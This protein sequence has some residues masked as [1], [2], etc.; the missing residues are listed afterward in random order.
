[1]IAPVPRRQWDGP[2]CRDRVHPLQDSVRTF[3]V[4]ACK[5]DGGKQ[6]CDRQGILAI[7]ERRSSEGRACLMHDG[8]IALAPAPNRLDQ[9]APDTGCDARLLAI[10]HSPEIRFDQHRR[11]YC[12]Y[13]GLTALVLDLRQGGVFTQSSSKAP[14]DALAQILRGIFPAARADPVMLRYPYDHLQAAQALDL[15]RTSSGRETGK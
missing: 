6:A 15:A 5:A 1:M 12:P 8:V 11:A 2:P 10:D 4:R 13:D 3:P 7:G 9:G 14:N